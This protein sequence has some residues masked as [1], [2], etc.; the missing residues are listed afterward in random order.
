MRLCWQDN[1]HDVPPGQWN[2]L[3][4]G[5]PFV[6]HAF[7]RQMQDSGSASPAHGWQ[8]SHLLLEDEAGSIQAAAPGWIKHNSHGEFVF[9]W[10]WADFYQRNGL[11]YYPKLLVGSPF[12]PVP[13]P[14]LMARTPEHAHRLAQAQVELAKAESLSG[15]HWNFLQPREARWLDQA[16]PGLIARLQWQFHWFNRGYESFEHFLSKLKRKRRKNIRQERK[17]VSGFRFLRV[18]GH[19]ATDAQWDFAWRMYRRT[20]LEK[21]NPPLIEKAF[22][23]ATAHSLNYLLVFALQDEA[24][25]ACAIFLHDRH[26]LYGRYWGSLV[27]APGLHFETCYYQGIEYCIRNGLQRFEP[28]AQGEHKMARGF[29]PVPCWSRHWL[30]QPE[31]AE[32]VRKHTQM[33]TEMMLSYG[34]ELAEHQPFVDNPLHDSLALR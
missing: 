4:D 22:F 30:R 28:G 8:A 9:D 16:L 33:E 14:R 12:S 2:A 10:H 13:G 32:A 24:P 26:T 15:I 23:T 7:L 21:G 17:R 31:L 34:E 20:F 18:S 11:P 19:E 5:N 1:L 27:Q 25:V 6:S 3:T 29:L